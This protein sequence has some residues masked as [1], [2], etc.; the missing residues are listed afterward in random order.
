MHGEAETSGR[1]EQKA[2]F[3]TETIKGLVILFYKNLLIP[4]QKQYTTAYSICRT[5]AKRFDEEEKV[6]TLQNLYK[7]TGIGYPLGLIQLI[8]Y[9]DIML[10]SSTT[11]TYN[12]GRRSKPVKLG[13]MI[14]ALDNAMSQMLDIF[15]EIC[16]KNDIDVTFAMPIIEGLSKDQTGL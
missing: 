12:Y 1:G 15:T 9:R 14:V 8:V 3:Q 5:M 4:S 2:N 13:D 11:K 7:R 10:G 6:K 16:V